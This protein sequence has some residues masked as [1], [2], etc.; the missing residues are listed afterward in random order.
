M[1]VETVKSYLDSLGT[2][3]FDT[4]VFQDP[5]PVLT[6]HLGAP[7]QA[8]RQLWAQAS[9]AGD[10]PPFP[11]HLDI[12]VIHSCN[13]TCPH[14]LEAQGGWTNDRMSTDMLRRILDE[15]NQYDCFYSVNFGY[16]AEAMADK[17]RFTAFLRTVEEYARPIDVFVHTNG[18]NFTDEMIDLVL[19]SKVTNLCISLEAATDDTYRK[20][21]GH[22]MDRLR[23]NLANLVQRKRAMG[24]LLPLIR[25]SAVPNEPNIAEIPAIIDAWREDVSMIEFQLMKTMSGVS[26]PDM[27]RKRL[28]CRDPWRRLS[29]GAAGDVYPC[30]AF[31]Y[32][33]KG[34]RLGNVNETSLGD[35]WMTDKMQSIRTAL[36]TE[37]FCKSS[38]CE[39]CLSN[40]FTY[41]SLAGQ[42]KAAAQKS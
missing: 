7:Y 26:P 22:S 20:M 8:Y 33:N 12:E 42:L 4:L 41:P 2:R 6:E 21:R 34:L 38:K 9:N 3:N 5:V 30:C 13:L 11:I 31:S 1:S 25:L 16:N 14:C 19:D 36:D 39:S 24:K 29:I 27:V 10:P 28:D 35:M 15:A 37:R 32:Y 18:L 40:N 17:K 23:Q